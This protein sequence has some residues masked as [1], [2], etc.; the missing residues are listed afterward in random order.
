MNIVIE[1]FNNLETN[2]RKYGG[3]AG[4]KLGV[5]LDKENWILKFPKS[6]RGFDRVEISY[7]TAPLSEFLGSHIYQLIGVES[8]DTKLGIKDNKLVVACK[9]FLNQGE[10][11]YEFREVKNEYVSGLEEELDSITS[12]SGNGTDLNEIITVMNKNTTFINN[13]KLR[14]RF[15]DMFVIDSLIGNND[16]N[17]GNWG[18]IINEV[19]GNLRI[20]PV[21]DNGNSFSNNMGDERMKKILSDKTMFKDSVYH[22]RTCVFSE[23]DKRINPLKFIES[24]Q[25]DELN[26]AI[27]RIVPKINLEEIKDLIYSIQN[28]YNDIKIT[29]D[30]QK[31]FYFEVIKYR[32]ENVLFP[33][34]LELVETE[35]G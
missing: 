16:R 26:T 27:L 33:T 1:N 24:K 4:L 12:S 2:N 21:Y 31:K 11:L 18:I 25:N 32:F 19:T 20:A 30:I 9:D 10:K 7:T 34:Y 3:M 6:T 14:E 17:N 22:S 29:S 35:N 28:E 13:P 8:H 15:W 23:N 5:I